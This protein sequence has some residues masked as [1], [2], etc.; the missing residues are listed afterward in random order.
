MRTST[1][2]YEDLGH[3]RYRCFLPSIRVFRAPGQSPIDVSEIEWLAV[4]AAC[5]VNP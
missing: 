1:P 5:P 3:D 4:P 2:S